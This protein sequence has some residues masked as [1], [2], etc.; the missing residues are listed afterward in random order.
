MQGLPWCFK[1]ALG[2]ITYR[3]YW[4]DKLFWYDLHTH[5]ALL[6]HPH[7]RQVSWYPITYQLGK[8]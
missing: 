3:R 8:Y 1:T 7:A 6:D 4:R 5:S 2:I